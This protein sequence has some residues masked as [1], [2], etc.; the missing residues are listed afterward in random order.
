MTAY[1]GVSLVRLA[2]QTLTGTWEQ[3]AGSYPL[4]FFW[5]AVPAPGL[6]FGAA[7]LARDPSPMPDLRPLIAGPQW[8]RQVATWPG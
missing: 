3:G 7:A 8:V 6:G 1:F 2:V 4:W 5:V